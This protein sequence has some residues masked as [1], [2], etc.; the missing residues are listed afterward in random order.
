MLFVNKRP[1]FLTLGLLS[2]FLLAAE[3]EV[4]SVLPKHSPAATSSQVTPIAPTAVA[5]STV[6]LNT[7]DMETLSRALVGIGPAKA[8]AIV[9]YR[10]TRGSFRSVDELLEVR[11]IGPATLEKNR[12]RLR[13]S[14]R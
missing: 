2:P 3:P 12:A 14:D 7:A 1:L 10:N 8:R 13:L 4:P 5:A 11:G 9:E 6:N